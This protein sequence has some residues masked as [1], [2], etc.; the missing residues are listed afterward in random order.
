MHDHDEHEH[1]H[2]ATGSP[3]EL[4][5]CPVMEIPV[6]KKD[7]EAKGLKRTYQGKDYYLCCSTCA[8]K[9]DASQNYASQ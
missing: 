6:N 9:F 2:P 4:A 8:E 5:T 1:H 3:E 7:A